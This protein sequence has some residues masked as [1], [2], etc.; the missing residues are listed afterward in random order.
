MPLGHPSEVLDEVDEMVDVG[1]VVVTGPAVTELHEE[2]AENVAA[3]EEVEAD[4]DVEADE[5][6]EVDPPAEGGHIIEGI[7]RSAW[8]EMYLKKPR[9]LLHSWQL[10]S[11][12]NSPTPRLPEL[13]TSKD[14]P[15]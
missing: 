5:V 11:V 13:A 10:M 3:N 4:E 7:G 2:G 12:K 6:D 14:T 1:V 8:R 9:P 15:L